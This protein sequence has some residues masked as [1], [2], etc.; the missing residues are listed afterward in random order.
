MTAQSTKAPG[1]TRIY[2]GVTSALALMFSVLGYL[3]PGV[4]FATWPVLTTAGALSLA[5]PLGLYLSRNLATVVVGV[6]AVRDGGV[7]PLRAGLLLRAVTDGL[8]AVHQA[9]GGNPPGAGFAVV[10]C[11]IEVAALVSL[12]RTEV[13]TAA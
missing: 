8:D 12:S 7:A 11:T 1:W 2:L 5:G 4:Q 13:T 9:I 6:W 3:K 10:M